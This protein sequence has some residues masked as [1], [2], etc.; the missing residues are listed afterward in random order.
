MM[1]LRIRLL[2]AFA[3]RLPGMASILVI[4]SGRFAWSI[5]VL[6]LCYKYVPT[7]VCFNVTTVVKKLL[8]PLAASLNTRAHRWISHAIFFSEILL[9]DTIQLRI[10]N[11]IAIFP[12]KQTY[13]F[14]YALIQSLCRIRVIGFK[15]VFVY[16]TSHSKLLL[17]CVYPVVVD[18]CI[19]RDGKYPVLQLHI[20]SHGVYIR[21]DPD[22]YILQNV[23]GVF[24]R[25]DLA[26]HITQKMRMELFIDCRYFH[27]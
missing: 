17:V 10:N 25:P 21:R 7:L 22:K 23:F 18:D 24:P 9:F 13:H 8:Q 5:T 16:L 12:R 2:D 26:L 15:N 1:A 20:F 11:D 4:A 3:R 27:T 6:S 14:A 19:A